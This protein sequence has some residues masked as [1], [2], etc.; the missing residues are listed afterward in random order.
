MGASPRCTGLLASL[1]S[2]TWARKM[3][4]RDTARL[5][6]G[7]VTHH[8][9]RSPQEKSADSRLANVLAVEIR[10]GALE[11]V[12]VELLPPLGVPRGDSIQSRR[13]PDDQLQFAL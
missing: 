6:T 10:L 2:P 3:A 9:W 7:G 13:C 1:E 5:A 4:E 8:S 11:G 12:L